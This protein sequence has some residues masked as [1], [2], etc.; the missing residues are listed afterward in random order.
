MSAFKLFMDSYGYDIIAVIFIA[1][2]GI[3][4]VRNLLSIIKKALLSSRI[5]RSLIGFITA[6]LK[7]LLYLLLLFIILNRLH[8]PLTGI[9]SALSALTLAI[10]LA[11]QDIVGGVA[12]SL[13][14]VSSKLFHVNDYVSIG[15]VEGSVK[16]I[17]LL[18]TILVTPDNKT[19]SIPN[20]TVFNSE[21]VNYSTH[22]VRRI[23][24]LFG[25]DYSS[26][27]EKAKEILLSLSKN[28]NKILHNPAPLCVVKEL[29]DSEITLLLRIWVK[30]DDYWPV[31]W[32]LNERGLKALTDGGIDV[33]Y[34]QITLS[35]REEEAPHA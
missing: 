27:V 8:I 11:L 20:K 18:H 7:I 5:D 16:E 6:T 29:K 34:N 15:G 33:P 23:D 25:I 12:T 10:G 19:I 3:V 21:I 31:T 2:F 13:I 26:D 32:E 22:A 35:Y 4:I 30:S 1:F 14:L 28:E 17:K 24:A 9:I